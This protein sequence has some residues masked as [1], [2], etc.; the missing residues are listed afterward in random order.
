MNGGIAQESFLAAQ[1]TVFLAPPLESGPEGFPMR[2]LN[3]QAL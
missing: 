3:E 2:A 1:S